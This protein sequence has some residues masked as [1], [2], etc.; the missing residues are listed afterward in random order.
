MRVIAGEMKGRHLK[1]VPGKSTR[2]TTDKV[3]E[4]VFQIAGPFFTG[5]LCLDLF[6]GSGSLGIEAL[7]RGMEKAIFIDKHPKAIQTI[8]QNLNA[9][10]LEQ[11]AEVYRTDAYRSLKRLAERGL[12]FD[13]ILFDP[14]YSKIDYAKFLHTIESLQLVKL[15]G[16]IYCEHDATEVL[17]DDLEHVKIL[18]QENYG[19]T[20]GITIYHAL[21][22]CNT[23]HL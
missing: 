21:T 10:H 13:L 15:N 6:A 23:P 2:P 3:K 12:Q 5:G 19:G 11:Q 8:H 9:L 4:A 20:I 14:P 1:T 18:K 7:S 16:I 22:D 17:P